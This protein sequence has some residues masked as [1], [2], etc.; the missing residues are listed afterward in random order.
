VTVQIFSFILI[1]KVE[2]EVM[3]AVKRKLSQRE[4]KYLG[5]LLKEREQYGSQMRFHS[6]EALG[7][8]KSS[9]SEISGL[10]NHIAD[11][12]TDSFQHEIDLCM[13]SKEGDV[14]EQIDEAVERIE[15]GEFGSC[16]GCG[17]GIPAGRL[18]AI[19][20][21][22]FCVECQERVEKGEEVIPAH[23]IYDESWEED[24]KILD[25]MRE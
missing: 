21:T 9:S 24:S 13:L 10:S 11:C 25:M 23:S 5:L 19:P 17:K 1:S 6:E 8:E 15:N 20:H 12:A 14:L 22:R 7:A 3:S 2:G 16:L 4:K 18:V